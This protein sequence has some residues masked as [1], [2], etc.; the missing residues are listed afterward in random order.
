MLKV[1]YNKIFFINI[2]KILQYNDKNN[3]YK[4]Y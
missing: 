3:Y 2:I 1:L 4:K